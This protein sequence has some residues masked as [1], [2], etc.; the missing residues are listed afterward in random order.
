MEPTPPG[1]EINRIEQELDA[2]KSSGQ[3]SRGKHD[4]VA[5]AGSQA[6]KPG[7]K[8]LDAVVISALSQFAGSAG[9]TFAGRLSP[10]QIMQLTAGSAGG[11][12]GLLGLLV[13]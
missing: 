5:F 8:P 4:D 2:S 6:W 7:K 10:Q 1:K 11:A 12:V 9:L 3:N 13:Y